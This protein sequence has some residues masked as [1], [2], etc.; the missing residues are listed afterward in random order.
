MKKTN[1]IVAAHYNGEN[2]LEDCCLLGWN[3]REDW[4]DT[5]YYGYDI[6]T[7]KNNIKKNNCGL[8]WVDAHTSVYVGE[9]YEECKTYC[10]MGNREGLECVVCKIEKDSNNSLIVVPVESTSI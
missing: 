6:L 8:I 9:T 4:F 2:Y 1:Y 5:D 10:D 7:P 3:N